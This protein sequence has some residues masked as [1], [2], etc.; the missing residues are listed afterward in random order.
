MCRSYPCS[1]NVGDVVEHQRS[2]IAKYQKSVQKL[3]KRFE[4]A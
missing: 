3:H 4:Y 1:M 2:H